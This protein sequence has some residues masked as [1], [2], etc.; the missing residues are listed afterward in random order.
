MRVQTLGSALFAMGIAAAPA[1]ASIVVNGNSADRTHDCGG[2]S[3][4]VN[5]NSNHLRFKN[6]ASVTVNGNHNEVDTG[7]VDA[8]TVMG[9][10]NHVTWTGD[11]PTVVN[12]GRNNS[13]AAASGG[14]SS[15]RPAKRSRE[16]DGDGATVSVDANGVKVGG[17]SIGSDGSVSVGGESS[18]GTG[19]F[20]LS[21]DSQTLT[22]DCKGGDAAIRGD[23]NTLRLTDCRAVALTGD[24]NTVRASGVETIKVV[25]DNNV[26]SWT[27]DHAPK[28]ANVGDGNVIQKK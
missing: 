14:G 16:R 12:L 22:H 21:Q 19:A 9:S 1:W 8:V 7:D 17:I 6:C 11:K 13:V 26:V 23:S 20:V 4:V 25:G 2:E 28:V 18:S 10:D 24:N 27:A 5:G 3:A 15:E